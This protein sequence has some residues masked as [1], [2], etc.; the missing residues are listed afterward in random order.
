MARIVQ[1]TLFVSDYTPTGT[2]GEYSFSDAVY[3]NQADATGNGSY[4]LAPDF[5]MYIPA[6]DE[7]SAS[8]VPGV[9]HRYKVKQVISRDGLHLSA[10][11]EWDEDGSYTDLPTNGS[12]AIIC[13]NTPKLN[14]G[15]VPSKDVYPNIAGGTAESAYNNDLRRIADKLAIA[16]VTGGDGIQGNTGVQGATGIRGVTGAEGIMGLIGETGAQ[17]TTGPFGETG[18]HGVTGLMGETGSQGATGLIGETGSQG[19][20]GNV[21]ETGAQGVTGSQGIIGLIGETGA[22]GAWGIK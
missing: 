4:D 18:G 19:I 13:E 16:S 1:G 14:F 7:V 2:P 17:G 22:Q 21:G 9:S 3:D 5:I 11:I 20:I 15:L 8:P 6:T 12:Y 10:I